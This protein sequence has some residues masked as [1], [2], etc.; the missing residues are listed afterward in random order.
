MSELGSQELAQRLSSLTRY[1][2]QDIGGGPRLVKLNH[3]INMQKGGTFLFVL[4]MMVLFQNFSTE[5]W[6]YLALHGTY[7]IC[8]LLKDATFPDQNWQKR[9][10]V[11]GAFLSFATVLGPYWSFSWLLASGI[12]RGG[13]AVSPV[14]MAAAIALHTFGLVVMIAAD[15]QKHYTLKVK[16]GLI[17]D[18]MFKWVRHPNYLGEMM[19]YGAYAVLVGHWF[20]WAVLVTIW[21][22]V[23]WVN[24][25]M[26]EKSLSRHPGWAEYKARTGLLLPPL[27]LLLKGRVAQ[28]QVGSQ[29]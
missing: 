12:A 9:V 10:T 5:M 20:P 29:P 24:M 15:A 11:G 26:K 18:G 4:L 6:V 21:T 19:L 16:R 28:R 27:S 13:E 3:V 8:W 17:T 22:L 23:F 1:L 7:G 2:S 14:V 25:Q